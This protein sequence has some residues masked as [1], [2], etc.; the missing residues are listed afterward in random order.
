MGRVPYSIY[1]LHNQK[2]KVGKNSELSLA[3]E[4]IITIFVPNYLKLT[5]KYLTL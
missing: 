5:S 1:F 4:L 3:N 2:A